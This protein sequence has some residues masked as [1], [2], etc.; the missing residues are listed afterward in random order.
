MKNVQGVET[1][2]YFLFF[3]TE[4]LSQMGGK[5]VLFFVLFFVLIEVKDKREKNKKAV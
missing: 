5:V 2:D 1:H 3:E 4:L